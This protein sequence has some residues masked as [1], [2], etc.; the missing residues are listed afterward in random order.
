VTIRVELTPASAGATVELYRRIDKTGEWTQV[1]TAQTDASGA[2]A[3]AQAVTVPAKA[4]G[5]GRY[6]YF[7]VLLKPGGT[8]ESVWSNAVR[9][10]AE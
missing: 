10:V 5:Y 7:R 3:W 8:E 2:A 4:A 9:A 1:G 6:V